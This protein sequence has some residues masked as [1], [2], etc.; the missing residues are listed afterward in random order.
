MCSLLPLKKLRQ[1]SIQASTS[2]T[3]HRMDRQ[4][5]A[6]T[7]IDPKQLGA[8]VLVEQEWRTSRMQSRTKQE[9]RMRPEPCGRRSRSPL[10]RSAR[11]ARPQ[12]AARGRWAP[13]QAPQ[14]PLPFPLQWS[15]PQP[16]HLYPPHHAAARQNRPMHQGAQAARLAVCPIPNHP[17]S[18]ARCTD[19]AVAAMSGS[20]PTQLA[21]AR[22]WGDSRESSGTG[23][24]APSLAAEGPAACTLSRAAVDSLLLPE[25]EPDWGGGGGGGCMRHP[26]SQRHIR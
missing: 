10:R 7:S 12:R 19:M 17:S 16:R 14:R 3:L 8:L 4:S 6:N 25:S 1:T 20:G 22:R 15:N 2:C 18:R 13:R 23:A 11:P 9:H 26:P 21:P 24:A 5:A